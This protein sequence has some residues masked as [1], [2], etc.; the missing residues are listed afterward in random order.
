MEIIMDDL[1]DRVRS[2]H[3]GPG[4][5]MEPDIPF[6]GPEPGVLD[7]KEICS[8]LDM[9]PEFGPPTELNELK[10]SKLDSFGAS[11]L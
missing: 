9:I 2:D 5:L 3:D 8:P 11:P 10:P 4:I 7:I 1:F 6:L